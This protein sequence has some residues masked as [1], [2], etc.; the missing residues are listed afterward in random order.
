MPEIRPFRALRYD[1]GKVAMADVVAPPY[2][3]ISEAQQ[4]ELYDGSPYNVVRLILGREDNRYEEARRHLELWQREKVLLRDEAA[5]IFFL[6]QI[7]H[8]PDGER[9]HRRGFIGLC[10]VEEFKAG[11]VLPHERTLSKPKEDRFRLMQTTRT[12]LS[13]VFGVYADPG[14]HMENLLAEGFSG[15]P[16]LTV[17]FEDVENRLWSKTDPGLI[18][19]VA[20]AMRSQ[21]LL[22]A[23]G[24]HRYETALAYRDLMRMKQDD[25]S[26]SKPYDFTMMFCSSMDDRGLAV[27][28][29]HRIVHGLPELDVAHLLTQLK[30]H[31]EVTPVDSLSGLTGKLSAAGNYSYGLISSEGKW[32]LRLKDVG[33]LRSLI[34]GDVPVEVRELD[35]SLLHSY[36]FEQVLGISRDA[37]ERKENLD[38]ARR[39]EEAEAS[40]L[41]GRAQMAFLMNATKLGQIRRVAKAGHTMPQKSTF[42]YPKLLSGLLFHPLE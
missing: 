5:A 8:G 7:F 29:T 41:S 25:R 24:H 37:Q 2:D 30:Q 28:P 6:E 1:P 36:M 31:F 3:V 18:E 23:D 27:F 11:S 42:F 22:I 12:N 21:T 34:G 17:V 15:E 9:H 32:L 14:N 19:A 4:Q 26:G 35:V 20:R 13:Q 38:Y 16:G 40:V 39:A 33:A 10:R